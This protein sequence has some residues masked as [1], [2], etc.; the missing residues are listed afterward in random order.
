MLI[1]VQIAGNIQYKPIIWNKFPLCSE[2][3]KIDAEENI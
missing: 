2:G 1:G 3:V